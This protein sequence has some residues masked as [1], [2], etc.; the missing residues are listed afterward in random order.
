MDVSH[1]EEHREWS[2]AYKVPSVQ[3]LLQP[4]VKLSCHFPALHLAQGMLNERSSCV[5]PVGTHHEVEMPSLHSLGMSGKLSSLLS[6]GVCC[7]QP[8]H[9]EICS[10]GSP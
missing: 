1:E 6:G 4:G 5:S 9:N 7:V 2:W 3:G 8:V 10:C